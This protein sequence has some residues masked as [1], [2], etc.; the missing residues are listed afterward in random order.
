MGGGG[1]SEGG[2]LRFQKFCVVDAILLHMQEL[3]MFGPS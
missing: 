2:I 3:K 1:H